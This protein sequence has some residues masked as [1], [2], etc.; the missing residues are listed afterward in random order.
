MEKLEGT[1][2]LPLLPTSFDDVHHLYHLKR[3]KVR[4]CG[5]GPTHS[6]SKF[7]KGIRVQSGSAAVVTRRLQ[8]GR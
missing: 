1:S 2:K 6:L 4:K 3:I 7:L 8:Q 5:A